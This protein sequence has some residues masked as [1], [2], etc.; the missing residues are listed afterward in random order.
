MNHLI[1][2]H[3]LQEEALDHILRDL[4]VEAFSARFEIAPNPCVGA[5]VLSRGRIVAKGIH[6]FWGGP[7]AEVEALSRAA[8]SMTPKESWDT[9]VVTLE[10]CSSTG[11]TPP[12]VEAVL[13]SGIKHVVIGALDPDPRHRGQAVEIL[14]AAGVEVTLLEPKLGPDYAWGLPDISQHFLN[15]NSSERLRRPRPWN[16]AKW[17]QTRT[18]QLIPPQKV[19]EGRWISGPTSLAEVQLLRGRVDAILTGYG[20][21]RDDDPRLSVRA[22]GDASSPPLRVVFDS[23]LH[24]P[25]DARLFAPIDSSAAAAGLEAAGPVVIFTRPGPDAKRARSLLEVGAEIVALPPDDNGQLSLWAASAWLWNR[26]VRRTLLEAGPTLIQSYSDH[27]LLDQV[28]VYSG[29]VAGG[30]GASLGRLLSEHRQNARVD[31]ESGSDVVLEY[32]L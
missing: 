25:P 29:D 20:T 24:T 32:F 30:R 17:A 9:L 19:G 4:A 6:R 2:A 12:C 16:I 23:Y 10:P 8:A 31:R 13:A 15:W 22:P 1:Q 18:G 27:D 21:V 28:R 5:A 26:G 7:H 11:K 14:R 3:E